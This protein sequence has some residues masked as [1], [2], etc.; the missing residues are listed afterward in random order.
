MT[1]DC[2]AREVQVPHGRLIL[3]AGVARLSRRRRGRRSDLARFRK[4]SCR[5]RWSAAERTRRVPQVR[6]RIAPPIRGHRGV[7]DRLRPRQAASELIAFGRP[8]R[9]RGASSVSQMPEADGRRFARR[10]HRVA[11]TVRANALRRSGRD[12]RTASEPT[13]TIPIPLPHSRAVEPGELSCRP[14]CV[15]ARDEQR[16]VGAFGRRWSRSAR[17]C[18]GLRGGTRAVPTIPPDS[19]R[20]RDRVSRCRHAP[21]ATV[22]FGSSAHP[23]GAQGRRKPVAASNTNASLARCSR[24]RRRGC[25]CRSTYVTGCDAQSTW[26]VVTSKTSE[27]TPFFPPVSEIWTSHSA[28]WAASVAS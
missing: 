15:D 14:R 25:S 9:L 22:P 21:K 28:S 18:W 20:P 5:R 2:R 23:A 11:F 3:A 17:R 4:S 16:A 10:P 13:T 27:P 1:D 6:H 7:A 12:T 8:S 19:D 24:R 26:A